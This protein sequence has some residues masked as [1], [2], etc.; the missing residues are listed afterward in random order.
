MEHC[1]YLDHL[2]EHAAATGADRICT[3]DPDAFPIE[4]GWN[5]KI[6][7]M[8]LERQVPVVAVLRAENDDTDLPHPCCCYITREY[9]I[10]QHP[11]FYAPDD[12]PTN[13]GYK[14]FLAKTGQRPDSGIG[15]GFSLWSTQTKWVQL[16][17]SNAIND[18]FLLAGIYG[19]LI[20]HL[21]ALSWTD[22]DFRKDRNTR[23]ALRALDWVEKTCRARGLF[24]GQVRSVWMRLN[25]RAN[26]TLVA[27]T[28]R[29]FSESLHRLTHEPSE[30]IEYLRG[31]STNLVLR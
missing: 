21:G 11:L 1:Y 3:M 29:I 27:D 18:H 23:L 2:A 26:R 15:I 24:Y 5:E 8:A 30:Y 13:A 14:S 19:D 31:S 17:R 20:F 7:G 4:K 9:Y 6:E 25:H 16:T 12:A 22:R 28:N 10:T